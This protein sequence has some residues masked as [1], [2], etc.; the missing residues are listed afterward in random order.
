MVT[1]AKS[2]LLGAAMGGLIALN[3]LEPAQDEELAYAGTGRVLAIVRSVVGRRYLAWFKKDMRFDR[4]LR[5]PVER[6]AARPAKC[7]WKAFC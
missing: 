5:T 1:A 7:Y 2:A 3:A 6:L 4:H